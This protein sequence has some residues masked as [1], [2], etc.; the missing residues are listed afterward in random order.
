MIIFGTRGVK[1]TLKSGDFQCPQCQENRPY[2]HKKVKKFFTLYFIPLIPLSDLGEYVECGNCKGTFIPEVLDQLP[3]NTPTDD[4]FMAIYEKAMM[5]SMVLVMLAD[6]IIDDSEKIHILMIANKFSK[7][8][9]S[10]PELEEY[11]EAVQQENEDISTYLSKITPS[12]N[13]EGKEMILQCAFLVAAAD[14]HIDDS[15]MNLIKKMA[16]ILEL[17]PTVVRQMKKEYTPETSLT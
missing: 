10:M 12:L 6:G 4:A 5:H 1:S 8:E 7:R 2:K 13:D 9:W 15:E 3:S 14:G 16:K 17:S 11:I